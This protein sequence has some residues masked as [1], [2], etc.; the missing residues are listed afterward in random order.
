MKVHC[1]I[2]ITFVSLSSMP[3]TA[4]LIKIIV[5]YCKSIKCLII[6]SFMD[7]KTMYVHLVR[8]CNKTV[9]G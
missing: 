7:K 4:F 3:K 9:P 1:L 8:R 5:E 2:D 6:C